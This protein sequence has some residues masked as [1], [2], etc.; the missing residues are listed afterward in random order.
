LLNS[1][2]IRSCPAV[3]QSI[4]AAY[5]EHDRV[6]QERNLGKMVGCFTTEIS[7][8]N[9]I[10]YLWRFETLDQRTQR[11]TALMADPDFKE[12]RGKVRHLLVKQEN[13]ILKQEIGPDTGTGS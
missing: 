12:F 4:F 8:L 10:N 2:S 9:Q 13:L 1:A 5:A 6:P 7:R 3:L 11:R